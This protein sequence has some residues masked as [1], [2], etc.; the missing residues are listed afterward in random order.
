MIGLLPQAFHAGFLHKNC[1]ICSSSSMSSVGVLFNYPVWYLFF[2]AAGAGFFAW[3]LYRWPLFG[4]EDRL[5]LRRSLG[6]LRFAVLFVLMAFLLEPM[7]RNSQRELEKPVVAVVLDNSASMLMQHDSA[8]SR[9]QLLALKDALNTGLQKDHEVRFYLAGDGLQESNEPDF[10]APSSNLSASLRSLDDQYENRNLGAVVLLSDGIYNQG[11]N[12][13]YLTRRSKAPLYTVA[14]GDTAIKRDLILEEVRHNRLAYL[15]NEFPLLAT[16]RANELKGSRT[17]LRVLQG[18]KELFRRELSIEENS[19]ATQ[20]EIKLT[21]EKAGMQ[22]Y[23][24]VLEEVEGEFTR[25]NN[26]K[27][28][29]LDV[30]DARNKVLLLAHSPHPDLSAIRQAIASNENYQ[31]ELTYARDP[32]TINYQELNLLILHQLPS[33]SYPVEKVLEKCSEQGIPVL[34]IIGEQSALH[35][36]GKWSKGLGIRRTLPDANEALPLVSDDFQLFRLSDET[37]SS[38]LRFPPLW[39]PFGQYTA[40]APNQTLL[41]QKIGSIATEDPLLAFAEGGEQ[42]I[43]LLYGE[44][45][46]RW[47]LHDFDQNGNHEA[48]NEL[49]S[50]MIQYLA[51]KKDTRP[52]R[53]EPVK[54][55]FDENER[56]R[57]RAELYNDAFQLVNEPE[58]NLSLK[59]ES[60]KEYTFRFVRDDQ[61]Y[62]L[63]AGFLPA[64]DYRYSASVN[65][66][67]KDLRSSGLISIKP[68]ELE[69][70]NTRADFRLLNQLAEKNG[71]KMFGA[72]QSDA[73][74]EAI[75]A[76]DSIHTV[77]YLHSSLDDLIRLKWIFWLL[78]GL[79]A[80]EWFVRKFRGAY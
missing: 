48:S 17:V 50:R 64:G 59:D 40:P 3:L 13:A 58:V 45:F 75:N 14:L 49:M 29:Y 52:F 41:L 70:L 38:I 31:V 28:I 25:V 74:I 71:G 24:L 44:G 65:Y 18:E 63:D 7:L 11:N 66:N 33:T 21:A 67:G 36:A 39:T 6:V 77:S 37:R 27:T 51:A 72:N 15:G 57:F 62:T 69:A 73:L 55:Q 78:V 53:T 43:G 23:T 1:N 26:T 46:W 8:G 42:K 61:A 5:W 79:L 60:G 35:L 30:I 16:V 9:Q 68:L 54:R 10:R 76:D 2:C 20:I 12:P 32:G 34:F 22:R 4:E 47:R 19:W 56:I 80:T